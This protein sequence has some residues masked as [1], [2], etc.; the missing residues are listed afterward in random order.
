[1]FFDWMFDPPGKGKM[2]ERG[3][4]LCAPL[5]EALEKYR[6]DNQR[7]VGSLNGLAPKYLARLP[8]EQLNAMRVTYFSR[9][10]D[11]ELSFSYGGPGMNTCIYKSEAGTW[12]C[13]GYY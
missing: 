1:M 10:L 2:A 13:M 6:A 3:Y 7:Y 9:G 4:A 11:Y 8:D 5:I 12:S